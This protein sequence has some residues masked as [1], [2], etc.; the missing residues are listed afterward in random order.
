MDD[1]NSALESLLSTNGVAEEL[2]TIGAINELLDEA[3]KYSLEGDVVY[4]ALKVM[5]QNPSISIREAIFEGFNEFV[6]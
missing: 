4:W 3:K 5:K 6:K 1:L 2:E